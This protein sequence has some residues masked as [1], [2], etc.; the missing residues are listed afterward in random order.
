MIK[1]LI[2]KQRT[3]SGVSIVRCCVERRRKFAIINHVAGSIDYFDE[4]VAIHADKGVVKASDLLRAGLFIAALV[5]TPA[6]RIFIVARRRDD[7]ELQAAEGVKLE[8]IRA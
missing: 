8:R 1:S 3:L 7:P 4:I 6:K 5:R 2:L